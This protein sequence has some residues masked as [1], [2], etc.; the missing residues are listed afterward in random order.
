MAYQ[1]VVVGAGNL[2]NV[3]V[4]LRPPLELAGTVAIED[5]VDANLNQVRINLVPE[6]DVPQSRN[7]GRV[8]DDGSFAF[9]GLAPDRYALNFSS[10]PAGMYPK[11]ARYGDSNVLSGLMDL[12]IGVAAPL[13]IT[14]SPKAASVTGTVTDSDDE[15]AAGV[16][17]TL[18]PDGQGFHP[19]YLYQTVRTDLDGA[20]Q[21][22]GITP[23]AYHIYAWEDLESGAERDPRFVSQFDDFGAKISVDESESSTVR[24]G[25]IPMSL[26]TAAQ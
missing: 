4:T 20:F 3:V 12:S 11:R 17:V 7:Q 21:M 5:D 6:S 15:P 14:L 10:L 13:Q 22:Q 2:D 1:Q 9:T 8:E 25:M 16:V 19:D 26:V 24:M 18:V 23:G